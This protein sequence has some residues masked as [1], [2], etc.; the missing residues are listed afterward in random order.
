MPELPA[1]LLLLLDVCPAVALNDGSRLCGRPV[2][3]ALWRLLV[4]VVAAARSLQLLIP[5][6]VAAIGCL[7][8]RLPVRLFLRALTGAN[9]TL[10]KP[11]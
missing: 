8:T 7:G 9:S 4:G 5:P 1:V 2:P 6:A 3:A 11:L 10:P